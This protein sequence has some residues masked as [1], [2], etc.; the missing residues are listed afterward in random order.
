MITL[1]SE[2]E[3]STRSLIRLIYSDSH[4]NMVNELRHR[5]ARF[6]FWP[7]LVLS[8]ALGAGV[9]AQTNETDNFA[10]DGSERDLCDLY[11]SIV[12]DSV[13]VFEPIW[14]DAERV[15]D[16]GFFD[17]RKY[18]NWWEPYSTITLVPG[19]GMVLLCYAVLLTETDRTTFGKSQIPREQVLKRARE[20]IRWICL[21]SAYVNN[22]YPYIENARVDIRSGEQWHRRLGWRID[23]IGYF[24]VACALLWDDLDAETRSNIQ[25]VLTGAAA[26]RRLP[27]HWEFGEMGGNHDQVKQDFSATVGA[28]YLFPD[29][30][31]ASLFWDAISGNAIDMVSTVND[32]ASNALAGNKPVRELAEVWNLYPDYSSD[33]HGRASIWYGIDILF[34]ARS[35]VEILASL[36]K[37]PIPETFTYEGNGF[38][39]VGE[40]AKALCLEQGGLIHPHG[41]EY[42]SYYGAGL[43]AFCFQ[44][45][46]KHD[47]VAASFERRAADLLA[48]HSR[49]V[50]Q[51]DYHRG[52]WA[53]AAMAYLLHRTHPAVAQPAPSEEA[54]NALNGTYYYQDQNCFIHRT[55]DKVATFSW[56]TRSN[57]RIA[58]SFCG[59]VEPSLAL[60]ENP[61]P[62]TYWYPY[63]LTGRLSPDKEKIIARAHYV[64]KGLVYIFGVSGLVVGLL[65]YTFVCFWFHVRFISRWGVWL[66]HK[67]VVTTAMVVSEAGP[68]LLAAAFVGRI[69]VKRVRFM[70]SEYE[71]IQAIVNVS[72]TFGVCLV[73]LGLGYW[74]LRKRSIRAVPLTP[75]LAVRLAIVTMA[76]GC[77]LLFAAHRS[78]RFYKQIG[79]RVSDIPYTYEVSR[80]DTGFA[81]AGVINEGA[82]QRYHSFLSFEEGPC[83]MFALHRASKRC[84]YSW[85]G[86]PFHFFVRDGLTETYRCVHGE[87]QNNLSS[88]PELPAKWC[89]INDAL[90]VVIARGPG[91]IKGARVEGYDQWAR[92]TE[93]RDKSDV[94]QIE[95]VNETH[96][97]EGDVPADAAVVIYPNMGH[98]RVKGISDQVMD[99]SEALGGDWRGLIA[100]TGRGNDHSE[101][102]IAIANF[103]PKS[104]QTL[105]LKFPEGAP[106]LTLETEVRDRQ[107]RA[108]LDLDRYACYRQALQ[109]YVETENGGR[110]SGRQVSHNKFE[111]APIGESAVLVRVRCRLPDC[112]TMVAMYMNGSVMRR[113]SRGEL[114]HT[115]GVCLTVTQPMILEVGAASLEDHVKP[116]VHIADTA[117]LGS[118]EIRVTVEAGDRSKLRSVQ[119]EC[120]GE[121]VGEKSSPP[122]VWNHA[123]GAGWHSY[124]AIA[125]DASPRGNTSVSFKKTVF[126]HWPEADQWR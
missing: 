52:S 113:W 14:T 40:W 15:P 2:I 32:F 66:R 67:G 23:M 95:F 44:A 86:F 26:R 97:S 124:R 65:A 73:L 11:L 61:R 103:G 120:D 7:T 91:N 85:E 22:P 20:C 88:L 68:V 3:E 111:I 31:D 21:T 53:K 6:A 69:F 74:L 24:S 27:R 55:A 62:F 87:G 19:N 90:A 64:G 102:I 100:P 115:D 70:I 29:H 18:K 109:L 49:A 16:A 25:R 94:L 121:L 126:L 106:L 34:E 110:V 118:E 105:Q 125:T 59:G 80:N 104:Q 98:E 54:W 112:E 93:Y 79:W 30:S 41:A 45:T 123:P 122:Y 63:S 114:V 78:Y 10:F 42:D 56:G 71:R 57:P 4:G 43:L 92:T 84:T 50:R 83:V 116:S 96:V 28:A 72:C 33:H 35:Y 108:T 99:I 81:T 107:G 58:R 117:E 48:R 89:A 36:T 46:V 1:I 51:F 9:S 8:F 37:R 77:L 75:V 82:I 119:L 13:D 101:R 12:E 76:V 47:P 60:R 38:E 39:G 17:F 5:I